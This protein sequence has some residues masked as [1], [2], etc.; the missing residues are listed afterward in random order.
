[1]RH[2]SSGG[3]V[4]KLERVEHWESALLATVHAWQNATFGWGEKDCAHFAGDIV[5]AMTDTDIS[6]Q[7]APF[8]TGQGSAAQLLAERG[9]MGAAVSAILGEPVDCLQARRGDIVAVKAPQGLALG[10]V[11][12]THAVALTT[13]GLRPFSMGYWQACWAVG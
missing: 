4:D 5:R 12:G 1:M 13:A 9:G 8:Y 3:H 2:L 10:A 11:I 6:D 7:F